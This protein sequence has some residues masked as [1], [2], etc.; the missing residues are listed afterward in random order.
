MKKLMF[1]FLLM[2]YMANT[3]GQNTN[4][5]GIYECS[6]YV[7]HPTAPRELNLSKT[8]T[9]VSTNRYQVGIAD[10]EGIRY[11]FQF[12]VDAGNNLVNWVAIG[13][14]PAAPAS[15]FMTSDNPGGFSFYPGVTSGYTHSMYNNKYYPATKT[16][17]MHYGYQTAATSQ[18]QY[19]RQVYEKY[20]LI[21]GQ[22][23][24]TGYST[25][26]GTYGT[27]I[28]YTGKNFTGG[29]PRFGG[30][31]KIDSFSI[32]SDSLMRVWPG[33]GTS[34]SGK[35]FLENSFSIDSTSLFDYTAPNVVN[36]TWQYAGAPGF[37]GISQSRGINMAM[38]KTNIPY[39]AFRD[40]LGRAKVMKYTASTNTWAAVGTSVSD[41]ACAN[42][43]IKLD[44]N[45]IP[46][47]AYQDS[48]NRNAI[49]VKKLSGTSWITVGSA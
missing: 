17:Y 23:Q 26:S 4:L 25:S 43:N 40:S 13:S 10:L 11:I 36:T 24:I 45:N 33:G 15:G 22:P 31:I 37:S 41:G 35:L 1:A 7:F 29:F 38:T 47:V 9:Q 2:F 20:V 3:F 5:Q 12:D 27:Q 44:N 16:F 19:Q 21:A 39:V 28:V 8:I 49:T 42:V 48:L 14:T 30:G 34:T 18:N 32:V 6:G 46:Y